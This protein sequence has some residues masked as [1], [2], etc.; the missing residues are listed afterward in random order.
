MVKK[1]I[2]TSFLMFMM[3][4]SAIG[5]G[6][7]IDYLLDNMVKESDEETKDAQKQN[8]YSKPE[9]KENADNEQEDDDENEEEFE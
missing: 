6:V 1:I 8:S 3:S 9:I 7:L 4:C 5:S 2:F